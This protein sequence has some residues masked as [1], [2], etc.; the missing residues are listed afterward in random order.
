MEYE[1][2]APDGAPGIVE[3]RRDTNLAW[4]SLE[5]AMNP[6]VAFRAAEEFFGRA[7]T[8]SWQA[9]CDARLTFREKLN[10][11]MLQLYLPAFRERRAG[12]HPGNPQIKRI[13]AGLGIVNDVLDGAPVHAH[14]TVPDRADEPEHEACIADES[15]RRGLR[16]RLGLLLLATRTGV[17]AYPASY[18]EA[19]LESQA[20]NRHHHDAYALD[21]NHKLSMRA[22]VGKRGDYRSVAR[23]ALHMPMGAMAEKSANEIGVDAR[24]DSE[25]PFV[26]TAINWL[27][28]EGSGES[29]GD[30]Q[31]KVLDRM[32]AKFLGRL[33]QFQG[34]FYE[35]KAALPAL[36]TFD[37]RR[38]I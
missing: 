2:T 31:L 37:G 26:H 28:Q 8:R 34:L 7:D 4:E 16:A 32:S 6:R 35:R 11:Q 30:V 9:V 15:E 1:R 13:R 22:V 23:S 24:P 33:T 27:A 12:R 10:A 3:H 5:M 36:A 18:R 29:L 38:V 14:M 21:G 19:S 25:E 17:M 20:N